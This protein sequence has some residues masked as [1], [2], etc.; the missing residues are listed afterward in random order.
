MKILMLMGGGDVGG[1]KTHIMSIAKN[2]SCEHDFKLV[3]FRDG[4]FP[5]EAIEA[6]IDVEI[7]SSKNIIKD[8]QNFIKLVREFSP[9]I[10]HSH[11]AKANLF[12]AQTKFMFDI[13]TVSTVH[14]DY[15]LDYL[16]MPHKQYTFG[17]INAMSLRKLDFYISVAGRMKQT[18][19][20]RKFN[21]NKIFKIYN[22]IDFEVE[23]KNADRVEYFAKFG[24]EIHENDVI[25]GI[26]ARL[27]EVKDF[28][29]LFNAF[30]I[31]SDEN[32]NLKLAVAG[33]GEDKDEL[34]ELAKKLGIYEKIMFLGWI[35]DVSNFFSSL[36]I[37]MLTSIS[38]TF[39]YSILEGILEGASTICSDVGGMSEL[40]DT[41][42]NGYIFTPR[43]VDA[44][45]KQMIDL[46][47]NREKREHFAELLFAKAKAE[48][49]LK[50]T[51]NTQIEIYENCIKRYKLQ[52]EKHHKITICGAYGKGNAGDD[53]ILRAI[54]NELKDLDENI[55][56]CVMSRSPENTKRDYHV[57]SIFTFNC[58]KFLRSFATSKIYIN[59]GGSLIQDVTS[60]RSLYFYL[61]T[62]ASAKIC[63][64]K[65]MMY[66]CGI[67]P[68]DGKVNRKIAAKVI[69]KYV[70]VITL[71]DEISIDE[72]EILGVT[73]P[74]IV[75][76]ADPTMNLKPNE[77]I[78]VKKALMEAEI[79]ENKRYIG[80]G[81]RNWTGL[82]DVLDGIAQGIEYAH[83][84]HG[85]IPVFLPIE[86]PSDLVPSEK[87]A[88]KLSCENYIINT[89]QSTET[90]IG[91][92]AKM[93]LVLGV[94]LHSLIF[95]AGNGVPVI[96]MSYDVKV[97]GFFKYIDSD[98]CVDLRKINIETLEHM[99]DKALTQ[100]Y[101]QKVIETS[102]KLRNM[103]Q[104]NLE[105]LKELL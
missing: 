78:L 12:A 36:D 80:I 37:N 21:P 81:V 77:E 52:K 49:S 10:I 13:P 74:K 25:C 64:A 22:G 86:Y 27:T 16:G 45:A 1:A 71:R 105:I 40:I 8:R 6:G 29:T 65:V 90:T 28:P 89:R 14:S 33:D 3:S 20:S 53:A 67:G 69:D 82:G 11:G 56:L 83:K 91:L 50:S 63:G 57:N 76:T 32:P 102:E 93:D 68:V 95:S 47:I 31:A 9:E 2:L 100:E 34:I 59:G 104:L 26:A 23:P 97:D 103:E 17:V 84:K 66:G 75:L 94:R 43:D 85:L 41:E 61:F 24:Y 19:I 79:P 88:E 30:K 54:I 42:I 98:L 48:F 70:D 96:G 58:F 72:L 4:D 51:Y 87:I 55:P 46:S 5:R 18:L 62:L 35:S 44:L 15:K 92:F 7:I 99:I 39:P 60:T 101:H 38:E 73:R